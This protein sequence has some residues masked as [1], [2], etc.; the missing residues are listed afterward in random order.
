[1]TFHG[2]RLLGDALHCLG[3]LGFI[4][5]VVWKG[6]AAGV[7]LKSQQLY[8]LVFLLRYVDLVTTFYSWY[9]TFMKL[10]YIL[11]T[12]LIVYYLTSKEPAKSTYAP[13][14]DT[15]NIWL[16]IISSAMF[17]MTIHLVGSGVVDIRGGSGQEFEVHLEH[18]SWMSFFWTYS[19]CLEP[20]AMLPQLYIFMKN[21][22]INREIR[23]SIGLIALY[24][25]S[26][27]IFWVFRS[28]LTDTNGRHHILLYISGLVQTVLYADFFIYHW[29]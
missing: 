11:A 17:G 8:L 15:M 14:Q 4:I 10:Y 23:Y 20:L 5:I 12:V 28:K 26:Y 22:L 27:I 21:R 18:Y 24:R 16:L 19:V 29:R 25:V 13:N 1:M 3:I 7:S 9:N 2:F 6:N